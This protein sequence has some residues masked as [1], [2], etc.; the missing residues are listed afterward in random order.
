[1]A[2]NTNVNFSSSTIEN[3]SNS[4]SNNLTFDEIHRLL[5]ALKKHSDSDE[6]QQILQEVFDT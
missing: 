4:S 2:S 5:E 3:N 6:V 1:M